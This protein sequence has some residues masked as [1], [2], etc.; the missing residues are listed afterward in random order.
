M[1]RRA[2]AAVALTACA[3]PV[4]PNRPAL[5]GHRDDPSFCVNV[6]ADGL[7]YTANDA[8]PTA[9]QAAAGVKQGRYPYPV[10]CFAE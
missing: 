9:A 7:R 8:P 2:I 4:D 3:T 1:L 10:E 6:E 5:H